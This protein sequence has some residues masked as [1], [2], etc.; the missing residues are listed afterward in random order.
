M[1]P[2]KAGTGD[3]NSFSGAWSCQPIR[4]YSSLLYPASR[5]MPGWTRAF[6][7]LPAARSMAISI[8]LRATSCNPVKAAARRLKALANPLRCGNERLHVGDIARPHLA[9][10]GSA[11]TVED[12]P[13]DH[14][15]EV[16]PM[17]FAVPSL[18]KGCFAVSLETRGYS[19][20]DPLTVRSGTPAAAGICASIRDGPATPARSPDCRPHGRWRRL[21]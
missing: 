9:A 13:D 21:R 6:F 3:V 11:T 1:R 10:D 16:R 19:K 12:G 4:Y 2:G 14:P 17:I 7:S 15:L 20:A 5:A 8:G 18:F